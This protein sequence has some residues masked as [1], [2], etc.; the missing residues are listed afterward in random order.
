MNEIH[1]RYSLLDQL[2]CPRE[3]LLNETKLRGRFKPKSASSSN[4]PVDRLE[5][6]LSL[7]L[8]PGL[9]R[10]DSLLFFLPSFLPRFVP[11]LRISWAVALGLAGSH[12]TETCGGVRVPYSGDKSFLA[13]SGDSPDSLRVGPSISST[14][15]SDTHLHHLDHLL[16][17]T[18]A[19][20]EFTLWSKW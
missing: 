20:G 12:H 14:F 8:N 15:N 5:D 6:P 1:R 11:S 2:R 7:I 3:I 19:T 18:R 13:D 10:I 9:P 4:F 17:D 16:I